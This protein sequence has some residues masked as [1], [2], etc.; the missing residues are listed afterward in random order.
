MAIIANYKPLIKGIGN[1][2]I[3][4]IVLSLLAGVPA[5]TYGQWLRKNSNLA[6]AYV[7]YLVVLCCIVLPIIRMVKS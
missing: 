5:F 7:A 4:L 6:G 3:M 2:N 1:L